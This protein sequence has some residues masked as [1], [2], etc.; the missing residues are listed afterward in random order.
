MQKLRHSSLR[1]N[2][3]D[4]HFKFR[5]QILNIKRGSRVKEIKV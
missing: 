3:I 5:D 2:V 4:A 1:M